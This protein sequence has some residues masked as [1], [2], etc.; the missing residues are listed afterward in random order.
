MPY[1]QAIFTALTSR[2]AGSVRTR[3]VAA[4]VYNIC[5]QVAGVIGSNSADFVGGGGQ[6]YRTNDKPLYRRGNTALICIAF[7]NLAV[8]VG[9][10]IFYTRINT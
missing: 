3:T 8:M 1:I 9:I 2:N 4:A 7:Y 5:V 10:K 6:I